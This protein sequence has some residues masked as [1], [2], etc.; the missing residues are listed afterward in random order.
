MY[1][2]L[3]FFSIYITHVLL[4]RI[5]LTDAQIDLLVLAYEERLGELDKAYL[6]EFEQAME[7]T[8]IPYV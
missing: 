2:S 6:M 7:R 3:C 1:L 4:C 8:F 5:K